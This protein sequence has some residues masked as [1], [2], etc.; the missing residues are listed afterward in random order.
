[1][2]DQKIEI[3]LGG[4]DGD[5]T[6]TFPNP[7]GHSSPAL[8]SISVHLTAGVRENEVEVFNALRRIMGELKNNIKGSQT[9]Y[10]YTTPDDKPL[11]T[12]GS[13]FADIT[14][15][16]IAIGV[17]G[18]IK[19]DASGPVAMALEVIMRHL[20]HARTLTPSNP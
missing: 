7:G 19:P 20:K 4:V 11:V 1:M 14:G 15:E 10:W 16:M 17:S 2:L 18:N 13:V 12:K 6:H 9:A 5:I 3:P 8:N